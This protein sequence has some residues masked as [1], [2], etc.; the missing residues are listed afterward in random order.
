MNSLQDMIEDFQARFNQNQ[1][2]LE[3]NTVNARKEGSKEKENL[4]IVGNE[5]E[6]KM[7]QEAISESEVKIGQAKEEIQSDTVDARKSLESEIELFSQELAAKI[8]GRSI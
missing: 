1:K 3:R 6:K 5:E 8:L 2:E 4:K 7:L